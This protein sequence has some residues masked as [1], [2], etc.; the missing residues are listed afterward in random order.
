MQDLRRRLGLNDE[1][2]QNI[3]TVLDS[4]KSGHEAALESLGMPPSSWKDVSFMFGKLIAS[5]FA[6]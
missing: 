6:A 5:G 2:V 3:E 1:Q 4:V